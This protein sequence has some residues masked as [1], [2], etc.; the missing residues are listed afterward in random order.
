MQIDH[1]KIEERKIRN[2]KYAIEDF[3]DAVKKVPQAYLVHAFLLIFIIV[4]VIL[5]ASNVLNLV[6]CIITILALFLL[7]KEFTFINKESIYLGAGI[8]YFL[9]LLE[10]VIGGVPDTLIPS[11]FQ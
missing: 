4:S 9:F 8:Y 10:A 7:S 5:G 3:K 6:F 11:F 2:A 1:A